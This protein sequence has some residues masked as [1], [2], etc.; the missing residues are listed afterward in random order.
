MYQLT[1]P[2]TLGS[3]ILAFYDETERNATQS[4]QR[5]RTKGKLSFR[6]MV[7]KHYA[8]RNRVTSVNGQQSNPKRRK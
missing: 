8:N 6:S 4:T 1:N 2:Q 3:F 7:L 5:Y